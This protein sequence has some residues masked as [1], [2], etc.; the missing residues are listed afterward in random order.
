MKRLGPPHMNLFSY[1]DQGDMWMSADDWSKAVK[2]MLKE[3][4]PKPKYEGEL[5]RNL[6]ENL[7]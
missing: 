3:E 6:R 5:E 4:A 2:R 1:L 7:S